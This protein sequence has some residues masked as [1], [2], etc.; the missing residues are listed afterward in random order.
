MRG[1]D[2]GVAPGGLLAVLRAAVEARL[3]GPGVR[4][5]HG[6]ER[7]RVGQDESLAEPD[8]RA[9]PQGHDHVR[10]A[11][12]EHARRFEEHFLGHVAA[13][14]AEELHL[15]RREQRANPLGVARA[16]SGDEQY[17][18][19]AHLP[20]ER[21]QGVE[22][23]LLGAD[24]VVHGCGFAKRGGRRLHRNAAARERVYAERP[25]KARASAGF[26]G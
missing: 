21:R 23:V 11:R 5:R 2:L 10:A 17:L 9:A 15:E 12:L 14:P 6:D 25:S 8:G 3:L 19:P 7:Q 16:R 1:A 13:R 20:Y 26:A 24:G 18:V 4:R 22:R